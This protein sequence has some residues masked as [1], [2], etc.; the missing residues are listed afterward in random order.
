M[1]ARNVLIGGASM[2]G[3][4]RLVGVLHE[5][6]GY[7]PIPGD[8][9]VAAFQHSYG[10]LG[11]S[12]AADDFFKCCAAFGRFLVPLMG[13]L[14]RDPSVSYALESFY[15][16]PGD[17]EGIDRTKTHVVFL[18]YA[19]ADPDEKA[20]HCR[21]YGDGRNRSSDEDAI[22]V[23]DELIDLCRSDRTGCVERGFTYVETGVDFPGAIASAVELILNAR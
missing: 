15:F 19:E 5:Q 21:E 1:T 10:Q 17:L 12:E 16:R 3:K 8:P 2:A 11:I 14:R 13:A 18:G 20:R 22:G 23:L 4:S 7:S 9:L 6:H